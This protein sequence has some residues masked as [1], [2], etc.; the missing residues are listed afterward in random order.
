M[1]RSSHYESGD[2]SM[3]SRITVPKRTHS[4]QNN[5]ALVVKQSRSLSLRVGEVFKTVLA[6]HI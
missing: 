2:L 3:Q 1:E 4:G 5:S 6:S